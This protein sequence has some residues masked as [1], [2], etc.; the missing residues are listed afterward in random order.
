MIGMILYC[1]VCFNDCCNLFLTV[2]ARVDSFLLRMAFVR[3][4]P[5]WLAGAKGAVPD[6][7]NVTLA[8]TASVVDDCQLRMVKSALSSQKSELMTIMNTCQTVHLVT[9]DGAHR[10]L[11]VPTPFCPVLIG[12]STDMFQAFA[13]WQL[14]SVSFLKLFW[15]ISMEC[16]CDV[17][18][19]GNSVFCFI[20]SSL[21]CSK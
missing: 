1:L 20:F 16:D 21:G 18:L 6:R 9:P 17:C 14:L 15:L 4:L 12:G 2:V 10:N 19:F 3:S 11:R 5:E 13:S 7:D 8:V